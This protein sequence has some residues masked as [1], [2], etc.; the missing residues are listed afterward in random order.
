M[1]IYQLNENNELTITYHI[2]FYHKYWHFLKKPIA[3]N[4]PP[5]HKLCCDYEIYNGKIEVS[6]L[7]NC[8]TY[9]TAQTTS[10]FTI[11][12]NDLGE[13]DDQIKE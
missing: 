12:N 3:S 7:S 5:F 10:C 6:Q 9:W 4:P 2:F 13:I 8:V 11:Q 1:Y